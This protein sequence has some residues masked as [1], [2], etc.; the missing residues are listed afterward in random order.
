MTTNI[1]PEQN[2]PQSLPPLRRV[3]AGIKRW[4]RRTLSPWIQ[5]RLGSKPAQESQVESQPAGFTQTAL[6][7]QHIQKLLTRVHRRTAVGPRQRQY[8]QLPTAAGARLAGAIVGRRQAIRPAIARHRVS[9]APAVPKDKLVLAGGLQPAQPP[10]PATTPEGFSINQIIPPMA[11][12]QRDFGA[13]QPLPVPPA[14]SGSGFSVGQ[15]IPPMPKPKQSKQPPPSPKPRSSTKSK[16]VE[17]PKSAQRRVYSRVEEVSPDEMQTRSA[18]P[19]GPATEV[20]VQRAI[21]PPDPRKP[22]TH[23]P[24]GPQAAPVDKKEQPPGPDAAGAPDALPQPGATEQPPETAATE[25]PVQREITPPDPPKPETHR[26][27]GPQAAP[28]DK[29]EQ[30]PA[31]EAAG[32]PDASPQPESAEPPPA[33][34]ATETPVQPETRSPVQ[35]EADTSHPSGPQ[36]APLAKKEQPPAPDAARPDAPPPPEPAEP[37]P[38]PAATETPAQRTITPPDPP[39]PETGHPRR[40]TAPQAAPDAPPQPES[41]EPP[42]ATAATEVPVQREI[43]PPTQPEPDTHRPSGPQA[44]PLAKKEQPP[45]PDAARPDAPPQSDAAEQ[46]PEIA[47]TETPVQRE[48]TPPDQRKPEAHHPTGPQA[49]PLAKKEQPLAPDAAGRPDASPRPESAEPP[50][51]PAATQTPVQRAITPPDPRKPEAHHPTGPQTAPVDQKEQPPGPDAARPPAAPPPPESAEPPPETAAT[52][53]PVQR[54]IT[55][56]DQRKPDTSRPSHPSG[57]QAASVGKKEQSPG[58]KTADAALTG[59]KQT[60]Q[61]RATART[62]LPLHRRQPAT[63][64]NPIGRSTGTNL[65]GRNIRRLARFERKQETAIPQPVAGRPVH[66]QPTP[67]VPPQRDPA[68]IRFARQQPAGP[69]STL[70]P[71]PSSGMDE[72]SNPHLAA[73]RAI[74]QKFGAAAVASP[75]ERLGGLAELGQPKSKTPAQEPQPGADRPARQPFDINNISLG[76]PKIKVARRQPGQK[77]AGSKKAMRSTPAARISQSRSQLVLAR[78]GSKGGGKSGRGGA[79]TETPPPTQKPRDRVIRPDVSRLALAVYPLVKRLLAME[80]ERRP[81]Y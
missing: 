64:P 72:S 34:T 16:P 3:T 46:P 43:T 50:P 28:V 35:F 52:E 4:S 20:P 81:G 29:K 60:I 25:T 37:P 56:P 66:R 7:G 17:A 38:A 57:P 21:T 71:H 8:G 54:T 77:E 13:G 10:P 73:L 5:S 55:P 11:A 39:K 59:L 58:P 6:S 47:A 33:P 48:I 70:P 31:P 24:S 76:R 12:P 32:P 69:A 41:A 68:G 79:T 27:T 1:K 36:A 80:R 51:A 78:K 49:A 67:R 44:A 14:P 53:T 22:E 19:A 63:G 65:P 42:P 9:A 23:R 74:E 2:I 26:P 45:A 15:R 61:Q 30:P 75:Q 62:R 18:S 40:P